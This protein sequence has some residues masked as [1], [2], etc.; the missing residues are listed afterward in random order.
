MAAA[1]LFSVHALVPCI[2]IN[3]GDYPS[4]L[5]SACHASPP[6]LSLGAQDEGWSPGQVT[7]DDEDEG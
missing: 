4:V 3:L 2:M 5:A 1:L 6:V 7:R